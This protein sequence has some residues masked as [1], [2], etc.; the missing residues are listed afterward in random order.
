M[1]LS[2]KRPDRFWSPPSFIF[3]GHR[4][5]FPGVKRSGCDVKHSPP[6]T[7][8]LRMSGTTTPLPLYNLMGRTWETLICPSPVRLFMQ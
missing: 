1:I 3:N 5:Y 4:G 2:P 8:R 6:L 7:A